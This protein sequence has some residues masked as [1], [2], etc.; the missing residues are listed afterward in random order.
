MWF[1]VALLACGPAEV[2]VDA[3]AE[4]VSASGHFEGQGWT[5]GGLRP[6][7]LTWANGVFTEVQL[8]EASDNTQVVTPGLVDAHAH[9][10]GLGDP[11]S[12]LD[13]MGLPTYAATLKAI[14]KAEGQGQLNGRGW[15]QNDW[16]DTPE[17]GWPLAADLADIS[18]PVVLRRVDGHAAWL[19][20]AALAA[21]GIGVDTV[22]PSGGRIVRDAE[23]RPT[24]VL[25]DTAMDLAPS[26]VATL[27]EGTERMKRSLARLR[28]VGLT[29]VHDMG[30]SDATIAIYAALDANDALPVRVAVYAA[31]D[32]AAAERLVREGPWGG[33]RYWVVGVKAVS[34]GALGSRGA[35][36]TQPYTD[37][38]THRGHTIVSEDQLADRA[39]KLLAKDAQ[40]AVHAIGDAAVHAALNAFER[41]RAAQPDKARV[42]LRVEHAQVVNPADRSR[43]AQLGVVASMQP[44]HCTSDMPWAPARLGPERTAWAY[45]WKDLLAADAWMAFGS[46][47]PVEKPDVALGLW[48]ATTRRGLD[49]QP[50][51][52][53]SADQAV[54]MVEAIGLF[55]RGSAR[56][57]AQPWAGLEVGAPADLV[58]WEPS[59]DAPW[60][61]VRSYVDGE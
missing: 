40:L 3:A 8:L 60:T 7:S 61:P 41:A 53:W 34:D 38:P 9:P 46:D 19:N 47:F 1:V 14:R 15:D 32:S 36:L 58:V 45:R 35:W 5:R 10:M 4:V 21:A 43:F 16:P 28:D 51:A 26:S 29:G 27:E 42:P 50:E 52:G 37:D 55:S 20:P 59:S 22:D 49:G 56:A 2:Q 57:A 6:M 17:G 11:L 54:T 30:A 39:T 24:G 48:S 13:L 23:G 31:W 12:Q 25:V 44:T 18:R 33:K